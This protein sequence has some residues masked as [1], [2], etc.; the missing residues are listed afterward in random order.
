MTVVVVCFFFTGGSD[1]DEVLDV[2]VRVVF[3]TVFHGSECQWCRLLRQS[4]WMWSPTES[5]LPSTGSQSSQ[6]SRSS[7]SP[8]LSLGESWVVSLCARH[9]V[10]FGQRKPLPKI[11]LLTVGIQSYTPP[12]FKREEMKPHVWRDR[13][14]VVLELHPHTLWIR[15]RIRMSLLNDKIYLYSEPVL[16]FIVIFGA[17][18]WNL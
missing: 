17:K 8:L 10:D 16:G 15:S 12:V 6:G 2:C 1:D 7:V 3:R 14:G 18:L 11:E 9:S 13:S 5:L 4:A